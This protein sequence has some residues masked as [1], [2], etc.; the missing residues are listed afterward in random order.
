MREIG[1]AANDVVHVAVVRLGF[2]AY[3]LRSSERRAIARTAGVDV[4]SRVLGVLLAALAVEYVASGARGL[5]RAVWPQRSDNLLLAPAFAIRGT[6]RASCHGW[7]WS[8]PVRKT[9][10]RPRTSRGNIVSWDDRARGGAECGFWR[11]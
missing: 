10:W 3:A 9:L 2:A 8:A 11:A 4:V 1:I 6:R 7:V 5:W